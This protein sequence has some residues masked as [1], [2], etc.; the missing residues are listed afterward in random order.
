MITNYTSLFT[1]DHFE[2]LQIN[3]VIIIAIIGNA[4]YLRIKTG[5]IFSKKLQIKV[6]TRI[7][8]TRYKLAMM[9]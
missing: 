5:I 8:N 9:L 2:K 4:Y 3:T 7:F 6:F 1:T